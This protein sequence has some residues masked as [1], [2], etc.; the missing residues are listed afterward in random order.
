M[1]RWT[2]FGEVR[3]GLAAIISVMLAMGGSGCSVYWFSIDPPVIAQI[4]PQD[5]PVNA[6]MGMARATQEGIP[7]SLADAGAQF[8][9][10]LDRA[11]L[12]REVYHPMRSTDEFDA[13]LELTLRVQ[14]H[15][16]PGK[17][18]VSALKITVAAIT[19][20]LADPLFMYRKDYRVVDG[21]E[22]RP[23]CPPER[24]DPQ[25]PGPPVCR[26][27]S[28]GGEGAN[29]RVAADPDSP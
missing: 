21:G 2:R 1:P 6:T 9:V 5:A 15:V 3:T 28:I 13:S 23:V 19:M 12:F 17:R 27:R 26:A 14:G 20:G 7:L 29:C 4:K 10:R 11:G 24:P 8:K 18:L 16:D 22:R 25:G